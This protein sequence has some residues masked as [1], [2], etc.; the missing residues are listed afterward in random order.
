MSGEKKQRKLK[1][2]EMSG[3]YFEMGLQYGE[4]C[5]EIRPM[6][7]IMNQ[8]LESDLE[9]LKVFCAS[10]LP[11]I[12][13]YDQN[14]LEEIKGIAEGAKVDVEEII[15]LSAW[16]EM[17]IF[18]SIA[19]LTGC[20]SFAA[21]DNATIDGELII[22]QNCD[23]APVLENMLILQKM[24]S[25]DGI[26]IM[27]L[28][29]VGGLGLIGINSEGISVNG[30]LLVHKNFTS[31]KDI[32]PHNVITRKTMGS[33]NL[34]K[35][36]SAIASARRGPAVHQLFGNSQGDVI[37]IEVTPDDL[38]FL[39]PIDNIFTH[40]N[41][42]VTERFKSR[43]MVAHFFPDSYLRIKRLDNLMRKHK[44]DLSVNLMKNLLQDHNNQPDSICRHADEELPPNLQLKTVASIITCPKDKVMHIAIGNPCEN[45]YIEYQL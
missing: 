44:G 6:V 38:G 42:F 2:V 21:R 28:A 5:P 35:V 22:G 33:K 3:T 8:L 27:A 40:S 36:I 15:L 12:Q 32:V 23:M 43:D 7:Q 31:P 1:I 26:N 41:N 16:Y 29:I 14:I 19:T 10:Y 24:N 25:N 9:K 13:G 37:G 11:I 34:S 20:T 45:E 30:N 4:A 39:Y 17:S 18:K